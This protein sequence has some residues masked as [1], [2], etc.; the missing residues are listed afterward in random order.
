MQRY[1]ILHRT[2]Y[3]FSG[4]VQLGPHSLR[5]RPREDHEVRIE[6]AALTITPTA[7]LRWQRDVEDNSAAIATFDTPASQAHPRGRGAAAGVRPAGCRQLRRHAGSRPKRRCLGIAAPAKDAAADA[8]RATPPGGGRK[9]GAGGTDDGCDA[10]V[11]EKLGH[12][13]SASRAG[14]GEYARCSPLRDGGRR[15]GKV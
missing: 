10:N 14:A 11:P 7:V 4:E 13:Q 2:Y 9:R 1:R 15:E 3:S 12:A 6:S 8:G 5:L